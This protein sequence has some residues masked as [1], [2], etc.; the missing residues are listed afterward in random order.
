MKTSAF[1]EELS[2][3]VS[4]SFDCVDP[5]ADESLACDEFGQKALGV[6]RLM[7]LSERLACV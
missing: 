1:H 5:G 2:M 6:G 4:L 7:L 3:V